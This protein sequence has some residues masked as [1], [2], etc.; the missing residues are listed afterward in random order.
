MDSGEP[1]LVPVI[2]ADA[3]SAA[4]SY[5]DIPVR[6]RGASDSSVSISQSPV[7]PEMVGQCSEESGIHFIHSFGHM[8]PFDGIESMAHVEMAAQ[9]VARGRTI[10]RTATVRTPV[11][12]LT[13]VFVT[14]TDGSA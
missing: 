10:R 5:F 4:A 13:E 12:E 8:L 9:E 2:L 7:T 14:P 11:G 3:I 6:M 1:D